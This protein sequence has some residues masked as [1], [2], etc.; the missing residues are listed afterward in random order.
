MIAVSANGRPWVVN[1]QQVYRLRGQ[2]WQNMP[3]KV[4]EIASG[5]GEIWAVGQSKNVY[6]WN[7]DAFEWE[8]FGG[9]PMK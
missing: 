4:V 1:N 8:N 5:N 9:R 2:N 6:R 3:G 7:P